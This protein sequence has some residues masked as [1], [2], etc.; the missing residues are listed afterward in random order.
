MKILTYITSL[1]LLLVFSPD[2]AIGQQQNER[3]NI[4]FIITDDQQKGL[5]G[6]E[7]NITSNTP[8][9]DR[10]GKEGVVFENAFVVTP[11]CSPSRTSFLTGNYAH[12]HNVINNDKLGLD[13]ISHTLLTW[14]RQLRESGY[15][16]A[17]FGKWHMGLDDSRRPG[18]DRWFSFKGQGD[19]IDG[20]VNDEDTRIQTTGYMTDII[21]EKALTFLEEYDKNQPFA[22]IVAHK[23]IHW[24]L[25]PAKRHESLYPN[26]RVD[27]ITVDKND[28]A[29]KPHLRRTLDRKKFYE[30][31]NVL[32]EPPESRR[33]R[34]RER[35][36][37]V[38][39]Q[40]RCLKSVDEGIGQFFK[41]LEDKSILDNTII[42]YVSDNGMLMGEHGEF[43]IKRWAYDPV[44][45]IP[46]LMRYPPVIRSKST[47]EQMVLNID[48]APTLLQLAGVVPLEP[49]DGESMVPLLK[50]AKTQGR[51]AFLTE[52]FLEKVAPRIRPWKAVRTEK[53]KYIQY[54]EEGM[55]PELYHLEIDPGETNNLVNDK[56]STVHLERLQQ[57]MKR[58]VPEG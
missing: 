22:M 14:P 30:Y 55:A 7:G 32:P 57:L 23:A 52:Y 18:Y 20:V 53:W 24:P 33:G 49:M 35:N 19:Y 39:D 15:A 45:R 44:I 50:E 10:I 1:L 2:S 25:L 5:L 29:G 37:V 40:H 26:F 17:F 28:L 4:I 8:N 46:M 54:I 42:V 16:T 58:F 31:Q 21:N 38:G 12:N 43:N 11:L 9:I 36:I 47:R 6:I 41:A 3:P 27:S 56:A 48:I 51:K 13:V 34:G